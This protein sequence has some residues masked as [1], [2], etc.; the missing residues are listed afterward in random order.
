MNA[1]I[2]SVRVAHARG[3][4]IFSFPLARGP[5][6]RPAS[7]PKRCVQ[8][9]AIE[10]RIRK[11]SFQG[12]GSE[13]LSG[14]KMLPQSVSRRYVSRLSRLIA[15]RSESVSVQPIFSYTF[16]TNNESQT[17]LLSG[18]TLQTSETVLQ[19]EGMGFVMNKEAGLTFGDRGPKAESFTCTCVS[20]DRLD[21]QLVQGHSWGTEGGP[22]L[23]TAMS[24]GDD[25]VRF[26]AFSCSPKH[27]IVYMR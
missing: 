12:T 14:P 27:A 3:S 19:I 20:G 26:I 9:N 8:C 2:L 17:I 6:I 10:A 5:S 18:P 7:Q 25:E 16:G 15:K 21:V 11:Y 24:F 13:P 1:I 23:L 22:L 4:S